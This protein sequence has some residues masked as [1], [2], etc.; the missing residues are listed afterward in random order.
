MSQNFQPPAPYSYTEAPAPAPARSGN[1]GLAIAAAAVTA[2]IAGAAYG[3]LMGGIEY[4]IGYAAAG[5]GLLVGLVAARLGGRNPILP[6]LS[7]VL[8]LLGVYVGY[9]LAEAILISKTFPISVTELLTSRIADVHQS[10][11]D[12][13]DPISVL[14]FALGGYAAFQ[15]ARKAGN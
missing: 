3:G 15:T 10:F 9:L 7:A 11:L 12:N 1:L 5:V 2:L 13:F 14:F 8:T 4:Q 6:A